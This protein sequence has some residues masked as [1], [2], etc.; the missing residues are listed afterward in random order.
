[1]KSKDFLYFAPVLAAFLFSCEKEIKFSGDEVKTKLVLNGLLTPDSIVKINLTESRFFLDNDEFIKKVDNATAILWKDGNKIETLSNAG[2]GYYA[3]TYLPKTGDNLR[4]TASCDGF[5]PVEC[6]TEIVASS[7]IISVDT[8]N[9]MEDRMYTYYQMSED[10]I[11]SVDSSSYYLNTRF[12]LD[13]TFKDTKD[14]P[15]YYNIKIYMKYYFPTGDSVCL[16]FIYKSDDLVFQRG[17]NGIGFLEDIDYL[18]TAYFNDELFDGKE[19]KL[20]V[21]ASNWGDIFIGK[22]SVFPEE[23][24]PEP[25]GKKI[26]VELQSLS[27]PYYLY[28][29]TREANGN[30]SKL[31]E[32]FSEPVQ[33]FS[34]VK[35][36]IG[37]LGSYSSS[38]Y[39]ITLK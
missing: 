33:I 34:N 28:L 11:Y 7:S 10:G 30:M 39:T 8:L 19:Y 20:K 35:G 38:V 22:H 25:V 5:D 15:N 29:K 1:M 14:I 36:G 18:K 26:I 2:K 3:G 27:Y 13:I 37:I 31:L 24:N 21:K 12:D 23:E 16:S 9:I 6:S 4:I 17:N 32:S